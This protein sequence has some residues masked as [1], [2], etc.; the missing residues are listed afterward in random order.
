MNLGTKLQADESD[1]VPLQSA[2]LCVDCE[3]VSN[4]RSQQC[5]VCGSRSLLS[6]AR[7]IGG[8]RLSA[9]RP[10]D[11]SEPVP[12]VALLNVE[13][14]IVWKQIEPRVL[15]DAVEGLTGLLGPWLAQGQASCHFEVAPAEDAP[16]NALHLADTGVISDL[17]AGGVD[18][19]VDG[20]ANGDVAVDVAKAA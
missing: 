12:E 9:S 15:N 2:V 1:V 11:S 17:V 20:G 18:G 16:A 4:G 6:L 5:R 3:C 14:A 7:I 8:R 10:E 19:V 13:I